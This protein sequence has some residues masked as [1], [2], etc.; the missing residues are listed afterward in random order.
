MYFFRFRFKATPIYFISAAGPSPSDLHYADI[1]VID[2]EECQDLML[3]VT[4]A[5]IIDS[6]ICVYNGVS[7]SC[8]VSGNATLVDS[9]L[10]ER[11]EIMSTTSQYLSTT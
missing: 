5:D 4:G 8:S 1:T 9:H 6:H 2:N 3:G 10:F 7:A 11:Y